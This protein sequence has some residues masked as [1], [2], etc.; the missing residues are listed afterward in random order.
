MTWHTHLL[1][2][3]WH[4]GRKSTSSLHVFVD[5]WGLHRRHVILQRL[6]QQVMCRWMSPRRDERT[7]ADGSFP[8]SIMVWRY[9]TWCMLVLICVCTHQPGR[10]CVCR[11]CRWT[12]G[13]PDSGNLFQTVL[14]LIADAV[15]GAERKEP[16]VF[17][18]QQWTKG[19]CRTGD[20]RRVVW[21]RMGQS[22]FVTFRLFSLRF[23]RNQI[24]L[25]FRWLCH[26]WLDF[27][28]TLFVFRIYAAFVEVNGS[29]STAGTLKVMN[30]V[31]APQTSWAV[32]TVEF[33]YSP[34]SLHTN[35]QV[36]WT[37]SWNY[38]IVPINIFPAITQ[39]LVMT[40]RKYKQKCIYN[41]QIKQFFAF[42]SKILCLYYVQDSDVS[43]KQQKTTCIS[44][45][46]H[47]PG[48]PRSASTLAAR[49]HSR[50]KCCKQLLD[51]PRPT[52]RSK[53][54]N[55]S[56]GNKQLIQTISWWLL[57]CFKF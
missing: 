51:F 38:M 41:I 16:A 52:F 49:Q 54:N 35:K 15:Q 45:L 37:T 36:Q 13:R 3:L 27:L 2:S 42:Y 28:E 9:G 34:L 21:M 4:D 44:L 48:E 19:Y 56:F 25:L 55:L 53:I 8:D 43:A 46:T 50:A 20:G 14:A 32:P 31:K 30:E 6:L 12:A 5:S 17:A 1:P 57:Y 26:P 47:L 40:H 24:T 23:N 18:G 39:I 33:S 7:G 29:I 10:R 22:G 11:I